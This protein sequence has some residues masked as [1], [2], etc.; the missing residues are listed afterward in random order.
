MH[1][2][3]FQFSDRGQFGAFH[4]IVDRTFLPIDFDVMPAS[5]GFQADLRMRSIGALT[6]TLARAAGTGDA[7]AHRGR[8]R[9]IGEAESYMVFMLVRSG[10]VR[11]SQYGHTVDTL[12]GQMVLIDSRENYHVEY[13]SA[14]AS[15]N[16]R[17]PTTLLRSALGTPERYCGLVIDGRSGMR[18]ALS[19]FLLSIWRRAPDV[20]GAEENATVSRVVETIATLCSSVATPTAMV[21]TPSTLHFE[22][23]TSFI[24]AHLAEATLDPAQIAAALRISTGHLHAVMRANGTSTTKLIHSMRLDRCRD[25]LADPK[26]RHRTI[27][28]IALDWGFI[29]AAHFSRCFKARFGMTPREV[30]SQLRSDSRPRLAAL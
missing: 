11:H 27:T 4:A 7:A 6:A 19:D 17:L 9:I 8:Q 5:I 29:D 21:P 15:L 25:A 14:S 1:A 12:P 23:A 16:I 13:T 28:C 18:A 20:A 26:V 10:R 24:E 2:A 22:R 3:S 30:R